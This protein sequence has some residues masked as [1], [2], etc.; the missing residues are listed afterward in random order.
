MFRCLLSSSPTTK[1]AKGYAYRVP[2]YAKTHAELEKSV[3]NALKH[4][5][6]VLF[7]DEELRGGLGGLN[8][9]KV[10]AL[11]GAVPPFILSLAVVLFNTHTRTSVSIAQHSSRRSSCR[12]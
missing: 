4:I 10:G 5:L 11:I 12:P 2:R 6:P 8:K 3:G 9:S 7:T 1:L